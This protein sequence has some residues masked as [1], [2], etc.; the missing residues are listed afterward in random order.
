MVEKDEIS[1]HSQ[2]R[3]AKVQSTLPKI[4]LPTIEN[5][6]VLCGGE[7]VTEPHSILLTFCWC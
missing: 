7:T 2:L 5:T 3:D 1:F 4:A 6:E